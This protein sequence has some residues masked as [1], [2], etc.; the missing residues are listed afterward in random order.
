MFEKIKQFIKEVISK[1]LPVK[2]I[3]R[4]IGVKSNIS[5]DMV[6]KVEV[7]SRM[8]QGKAEWID[9]DAV[10]SLRLEQGICKEFANATLNEMT[11][12]VTSDKLESIF[13][14]AV[15]NL[16][17]NLQSGL[18]VG[19]FIIKPL[20][21]N[22][23]E[24]ITADRFIPVEFDAQGRLTKVVFVAHK[25]IDEN[26]VYHRLEFHS[27]DKNGLTIINKAFFSSSK[28]DLGREVPLNSIEE[29]SNL[30]EQINYPL[31][32]RPDFGYYRNPIKNEID[33][34]FCGVSIYDSAVGLIKKAD[35]QFGRIDWEYESGERAVH[36]DITAMNAVP[37]VD[38][39][40]KTKYVM[41]KLNKRLYRS[42]N[43]E[44]KNGDLLKEYSPEFRDANLINGL[45]EYKRN[46][47]FNVGL[48]YGD[49]SNPQ[50][51]EKSA[52]EVKASKK[53]KYNTVTAIQ[54]NLKDCLDDLVYALA[55]YNGLTTSGYEFI[56]DFKDNILVDEETERQ[57][58]RQDVS[59]GVMSLQEYRMKWYG[60]DEETAQ[61][62]LPQQANIIE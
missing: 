27:L 11:T 20:G 48:S 10:Y 51:V 2:T 32:L 13:E 56:C 46:I 37:R 3:D 30:K 38:G 16:N 39:K 21:E 59:M 60:E 58:D 7:W 62:M 41:P 29:W 8:Y 36:V 1:M 28:T 53:R 4:A 14:S 23:V 61:K 40:G 43:I 50:A 19:S 57:Q 33:G 22:K 44:D 47:E 6:N 9:N 55:F 54:K 12:K 18:A 26:N 35:V 15:R 49:L 5:S 24:Y 34:S 17:E 52:T 42:I 25:V 31:M 45:E